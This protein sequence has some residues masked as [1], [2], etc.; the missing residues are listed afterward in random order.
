MVADRIRRK[1][2]WV[3]VSE[4]NSPEQVSAAAKACA[5]LLVSA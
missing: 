1:S 5:V 4:S 2:G 3:T